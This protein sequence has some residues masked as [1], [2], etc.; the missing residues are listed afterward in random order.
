[1]ESILDQGLIAC[2]EAIPVLWRTEQSQIDER[3]SVELQ[4]YWTIVAQDLGLSVEDV[5][6]RWEKLKE[7][8][9]AARELHLLNKISNGSEHE[10]Q[11]NSAFPYYNQMQFLD[12]VLDQMRS[13]KKLKVEPN[14]EKIVAGGVVDYN[15]GVSICTD[16]SSSFEKDIMDYIM[17]NDRAVADGEAAERLNGSNTDSFDKILQNYIGENYEP[18]SNGLR[19]FLL[20]IQDIMK[21]V[22]QEHRI[23][24]QHETLKFLD[25][26]QKEFGNR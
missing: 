4:K 1:M 22:P 6:N 23:Q 13:T 10:G 12:C 5:Q 19:S 14:S 9:L 3:T 26:K 15:S 7:E 24:V 18:D 16:D 25:Y 20:Q 21:Q 11:D 8:Y 2:V 17:E